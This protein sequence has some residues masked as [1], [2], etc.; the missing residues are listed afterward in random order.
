M[1]DSRPQRPA[2]RA[3]GAA[4]P[5]TLPILPIPVGQSTYRWLAMRDYLLGRTGPP[6]LT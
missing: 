6:P 4:F 1:P 2:L 5:H 3:L